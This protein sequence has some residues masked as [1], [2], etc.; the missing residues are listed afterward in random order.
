MNDLRKKLIA[1]IM[2]VAITVSLTPSLGLAYAEDDSADVP[3][4]AVAEE[5]ADQEDYPEQHDTDQQDVNAGM[6]EET[7]QI[8]EEDPA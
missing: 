7:A 5:A 4:A 8:I 3:A 6:P 2:A 1:L